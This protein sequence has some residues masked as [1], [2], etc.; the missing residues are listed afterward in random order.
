MTDKER[1]KKIAWLTR[2]RIF[3]R[4]IDRLRSELAMWE[5][6]AVALTKPPS[7]A[8]HIDDPK[9]L[10]TM[11][12]EEKRLN[13]MNPVVVRGGKALS[14]ADVVVEIVD[15]ETEINREIEQL[16]K[17]RREIVCRI[18]GLDNLLEQEVLNL[19][20]ISGLYFEQVTLKIGYSYRQTLRIHNNAIKNIEID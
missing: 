8:V 19:R 2:Y 12:K 15:L 1:R 18:D 10:A 13:S 17:M 6:R 9:I 5:T 7:Y 3:D 20:Y 11:T 4:K 14:M 16:I